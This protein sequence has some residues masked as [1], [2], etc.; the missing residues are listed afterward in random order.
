MTEPI[1]PFH[2]WKTEQIIKDKNVWK[3]KDWYWAAYGRY[4][5]K[6]RSIFQ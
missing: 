3:P 1:L 6:M 4:C 5:L 2:Q